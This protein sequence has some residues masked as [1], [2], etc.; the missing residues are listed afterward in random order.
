M[1]EPLST[2]KIGDKYKYRIW[3]LLQDFTKHQQRQIYDILPQRLGVTSGSFTNW[4]YITKSDNKNIPADCLYQ[5]A[6]FFK[7]PIEKLWN[8]PPKSLF[9]ERLKIES[10]SNQNHG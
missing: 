5:L 1:R 6:T 10:S 4:I 2:E 7:V 8:E 9:I 3:H